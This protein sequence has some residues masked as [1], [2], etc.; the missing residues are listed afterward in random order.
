MRLASEGICAP[1]A[2]KTSS[3][4][5]AIALR[6]DYSASGSLAGSCGGRPEIDVVWFL[7]EI[8]IESSSA[9]GTLTTNSSGSIKLTGS[10]TRK[11]LAFGETKYLLRD[12]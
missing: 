7:S 11:I 4:A 3:G 2:P 12:G 8:F 6:T 9:T 5:G 1:S 10:Q